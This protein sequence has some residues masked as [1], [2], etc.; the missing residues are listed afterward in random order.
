MN[1]NGTDGVQGSGPIWRGPA[2]PSRGKLRSVI[3]RRMKVG[4]PTALILAFAFAIALVPVIRVDVWLAQSGPTLLSGRVI[5]LA[6]T[7]LAGAALAWWV[8]QESRSRLAAALTAALWL[9]LSPVYVWSTFF[10]ASSVCA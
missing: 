8:W 6:A 2:T 9:S 4:L 5:A 10:K 7:L 1:G 3:P